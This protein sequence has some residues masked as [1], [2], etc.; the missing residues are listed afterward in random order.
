MIKFKK[1]D[2]IE[3]GKEMEIASKALKDQELLFTIWGRIMHHSTMIEN[4]LKEHLNLENDK[5]G[6]DLLIKKFE[7]D[8]KGKR[9]LTKYSKLIS[10]LKKLNKECRIVWA[11]GCLTYSLKK[12][13]L[14]KHLIY[15]KKNRAG[16]WMK[17]EIEIKNDYFDNIANI[18]FPRVFDELLKMWDARD[19]EG[20][21]QL[22][23]KTPF[24]IPVN[25]GNG[26]IDFI[27]VK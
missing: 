18:L 5:M 25:K 22:K 4:M 19:S 7:E 21:P 14:I 1:L 20:N 12:G 15:A 16:S 13:K 8:C 24:I 9:C 10:L 2:K 27:F 11:H 26:I 3:K 23:T 17:K 6:L